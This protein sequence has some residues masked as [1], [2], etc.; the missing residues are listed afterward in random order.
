MTGETLAEP[1]TAPTAALSLRL[2]ELRTDDALNAWQAWN[3][4]RNAARD[5][6]KAARGAGTIP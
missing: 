2:L 1:M 3:L 4:G 5:T 6:L